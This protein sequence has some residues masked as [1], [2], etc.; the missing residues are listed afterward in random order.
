MAI[1]SAGIYIIVF[2]LLLSSGNAADELSPEL[3]RFLVAAERG[4]LN[5]V[6]AVVGQVYVNGQ[7][8]DGMNALLLAVA[9]GHDDVVLFL[10]KRG[11][12]VNHV[13]RSGE[14][15]LTIAQ[16]K[17][18]D[19]I[20]ESLKEGGAVEDLEEARNLTAIY[21]EEFRKIKERQKEEAQKKAAGEK[22]LSL[23]KK[24]LL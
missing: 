13:N 18:N 15:A 22:A 21:E 2:F 14:T 4:D 9:N 23:R 3:E 11:V 20:V 24:A 5:E 1:R 6:Q 12:N 17:G 8:A 7:R 16:K 19:K 10:L